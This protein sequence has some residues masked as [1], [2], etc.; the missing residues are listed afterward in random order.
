MVVRGGISEGH[1]Q[2]VEELHR[3]FQ[4]PFSVAESAEAL[5]LDRS[6][7]RRL[8]AHLAARGWL[9]RVRRDTYITVPLGAERPEE[10]REDPW[11]VAARLFSPG[12]LAGWT[13]CE[14][15]DLTD[16]AEVLRQLSGER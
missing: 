14:H 16:T 9:N 1:R 8:L 4:R 6:K 3:R 11:V 15:W 10:W 2:R 7:T 5:R 13:A 12:Y